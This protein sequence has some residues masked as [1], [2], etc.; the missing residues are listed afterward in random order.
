MRLKVTYESLNGKIFLPIHY[1]FYIQSLIYKTLSPLLAKKIHNEGFKFEKRSFK[2]FSFSRILEKGKKV[3]INGKDMLLYE[4]CISFIVSSP[5][6]DLIADFGGRGLKEREFK[7]LNQQIFMSKI[8]VITTPR[9][10]NSV[11]IKMLSP[12]TIHSTLKTYD[13]KKRS[14]YYKPID[15]EFSE[16]IEKNAIKKFKLLY[17]IEKDNLKLEIKPYKFSIKNNFHIIKFKNTPIEA[18]S[19]IYE[20]K[21]SNELIMTTYETGLG[22]RNSE[23][24]GLWDIW[25]GGRN[26]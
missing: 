17:N 23:G 24:F 12:I 9:I 13:D 19:G 6:V 2:L 11:L 25:K 8:E 3:N 14:I 20:L 1:N 4:N 15:K 16:L 26:A 21:G 22:D 5:I 7:L 10:E 18:Y